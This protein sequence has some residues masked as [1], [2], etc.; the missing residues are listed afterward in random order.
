MVC[1]S[2]LNHENVGFYDKNGTV[3]NLTVIM[4]RIANAKICCRLIKYSRET[5]NFATHF[6]CL[7]IFSFS[8]LVRCASII[9]GMWN[10]CC[11]S[12]CLLNF[13]MRKQ[14]KEQQNVLAYRHFWTSDME[15]EWMNM[16]WNVFVSTKMWTTYK[17]N[18]IVCIPRA[19]NSPFIYFIRSAYIYVDFV[20][21]RCLSDALSS[22]PS[23]ITRW[24]IDTHTHISH[25]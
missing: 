18:A 11:F 7:F 22:S 16:V 10:E 17:L 24:R 14:W 4:R 20:F 25:T 12:G 9:I 15:S 21:A 13:A 8:C 1:I 23:Y 6:F 2:F 19:A 3:H 5:K